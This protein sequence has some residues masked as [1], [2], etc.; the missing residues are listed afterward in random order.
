MKPKRVWKL[1]PQKP[2]ERLVF[3][4]TI[5]LKNGRILYAQDYGLSAFSF[6]AKPRTR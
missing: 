1:R 5:R 4:K 3:T 6:W 2:G